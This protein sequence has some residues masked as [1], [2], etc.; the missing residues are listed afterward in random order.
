LRTDDASVTADGDLTIRVGGA[1]LTGWQRIEL[2]FSVERYLR[3][4]RLR[5]RASKGPRVTLGRKRKLTLHQ[6][7]EAIQ[8]HDQGESVREIARSYNVN[9]STIF[10]LTA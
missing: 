4:N 8:R 3:P 5:T 2:E 7:R 6:Q 1:E 9:P 10:R